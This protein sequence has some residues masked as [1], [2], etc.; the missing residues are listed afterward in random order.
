MNHL[1]Y[2]GPIVAGATMIDHFE[3]FEEFEAV[4]SAFFI[5]IPALMEDNQRYYSWAIIAAGT[6]FLGFYVFRQWQL[7]RQGHVISPHKV[8]LLAST[9]VVSVYTWGFNSFGEAFFIMNLFHGLQYF[10]LV[11]AS[12]QRNM[13]RLFR[14]ENLRFG[15]PLTLALFVG[16]ALSYGAWVEAVDTNLQF[17]W[18]ITLI[19][20]IMHFWYDG[21]IGSVRRKQV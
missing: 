13:M 17:L 16:S 18:S 4:G 20:S 11:W 6:L 1:L 10:G 3:D 21:F 12:E 9:G 7:S 2:A 8:F 14:F 15:K 19:V 5:Q